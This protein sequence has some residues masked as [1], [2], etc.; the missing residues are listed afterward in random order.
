M[1][2]DKWKASLEAIPDP[3]GTIIVG[4]Q[5]EANVDYFGPPSGRAWWGTQEAWLPVPGF[6]HGGSVNKPIDAAINPCAARAGRGLR[7]HGL[8]RRSRGSE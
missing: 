1:F 3:S 4:D 7:Q 2:S 5:G 6:R 8:R